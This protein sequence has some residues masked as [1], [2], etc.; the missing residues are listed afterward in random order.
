MGKGSNQYARPAQA[1]D[2]M[3]PRRPVLGHGVEADKRPI[4]DKPPE[5]V[6][7]PLDRRRVQMRPN[8]RLVLATIDGRKAPQLLA[9]T[10]S[11]QRHDRGRPALITADRE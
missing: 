11:L 4:A 5:R 9:A 3:R 10:A 2:E 6:A 1:C 8:Y 7:D